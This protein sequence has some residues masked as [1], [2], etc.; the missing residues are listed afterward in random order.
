MIARLYAQWV[1]LGVTILCVVAILAAVIFAMIAAPRTPDTIGW[2]S[3]A[4][5]GL[6]VL[7][8]V[9]GAVATHLWLGPYARAEYREYAAVRRTKRLK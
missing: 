2:V 3:F 5:L 9:S 4:I 6:F 7:A 1:W 8:A